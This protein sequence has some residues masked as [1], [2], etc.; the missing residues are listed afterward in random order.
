MVNNLPAMRETWVLSLGREDPLE[1][2]LAIHSSILAWRI[3]WTEEPG[4]LQSMELQRVGHDWVTN[5]FTFNYVF[6][7]HNYKCKIHWK[8]THQKPSNLMTNSHNYWEFCQYSFRC[9]FPPVIV[10][11]FPLW[12]LFI[13]PAG[14]SILH[15]SH[16]RCLAFFFLFFICSVVNFVIHWNEIAMGLHVF[17]IPIPPPTSLSTRSL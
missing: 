11:A 1:K 15:V 4:R 8:P 3:S 12:V 17:P 16:F 5:T 7:T 2:G 10:L 14:M 6:K 9:D 13:Q